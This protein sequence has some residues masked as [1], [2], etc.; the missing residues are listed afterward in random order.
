MNSRCDALCGCVAIHIS[1]LRVQLEKQ[2]FIVSAERERNRRR[3]KKAQKFPG[4]IDVSLNWRYVD[5]GQRRLQKV[6]GSRP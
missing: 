2:S 1:P 5:F 4:A 6:F 3:G